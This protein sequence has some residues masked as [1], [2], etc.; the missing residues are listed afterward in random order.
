MDETLFGDTKA[1]AVEDNF[2]VVRISMGLNETWLSPK[3][4]RALSSWL[5]KWEWEHE[6]RERRARITVQVPGKT[7]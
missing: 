4:V 6:E 5:S 1:L 3:E 2:G 7:S